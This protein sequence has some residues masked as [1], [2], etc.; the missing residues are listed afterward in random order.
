MPDLTLFFPP[1][2]LWGTATASHQV[3]GQ[4]ITSDWWTA[5]KSGAI[6]YQSGRA[7]NWLDLSTA[8]ADFDLAAEMGTTSHRLSIEWARLEPEPGKFDPDAREYYR[9]ILAALKARGIE[10]MVTLH[11]FSLPQWFVD[12]GDFQGERPEEALLRY[13]S[14]VISMFGDIVTKWITFNEPVVFFYLR[15]LARVFPQPAG[16]SG[17]RS[18]L[19][20]LRSMLRC[21]AAMYHKIKGAYP[22]AEVGLA[23]QWVIFDGQRPGHIA[24]RWWAGRLSWAF[25]HMWMNALKRGRPSLLL[26]GGRIRHLANTFDFVGLNYYTRR[27]V[28]FLSLADQPP[29]PGAQMS[30]T[31]Y[32]ELYPEGLMQAIRANLAYGKPIYITENGLPDQKDR[33][34]PAFLATHLHQVWRAIN[35]NSPI[36]GYYHWSLIDNFEWDRG[37]TQRFGLIALDPDTQERRPRPS[38]RMYGE[39]CRS[40][41]LS[42]AIIEKYAP[43]ILDVMFPE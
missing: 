8:L 6:P 11:H 20:G 1:D 4:N 14:Y 38:G 18:G 26:G 32:S 37:W 3:E 5:E 31:N 39:I 7:A 15:H 40:N 24:D 22:Q 17:W 29:R 35:F 25:N 36:M 16:K 21:H 43:H 12:Q 9:A 27:G 2:F 33:Q 30:E 13:T 23:K 10:P 19:R 42:T 41:T 34:R 28:R